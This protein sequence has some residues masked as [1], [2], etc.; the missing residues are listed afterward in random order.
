LASQ[1]VAGLSAFTLVGAESEAIAIAPIAVATRQRPVHV[2][3]FRMTK[4]SHVKQFHRRY[5]Q[6]LRPERKLT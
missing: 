6:R 5:T 1:P 3:N 4:N 2:H